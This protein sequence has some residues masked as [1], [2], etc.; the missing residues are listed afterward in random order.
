MITNSIRD[1]YM[2]THFPNLI[3]PFNYVGWF[4]FVYCPEARGRRES[5]QFYRRTDLKYVRICAQGVTVV[6]HTGISRIVTNYKNTKDKTVSIQPNVDFGDKII[7]GLTLLK[8]PNFKN[9]RNV[10]YDYK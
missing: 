10:F 8:I 2:N 1:V 7:Y 9:K 6:S 4:V 5:L 3:T